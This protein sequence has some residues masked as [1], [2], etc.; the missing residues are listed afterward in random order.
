MKRGTRAHTQNQGLQIIS[1]KRSQIKMSFGMV[2]S[3]ILIIIFL[4]FAF[5]GIKKFLDM[6]I[7]IQTAQFVND[8]QADIDKIWKGSQGSQEVTYTLPKK[9]NEVCF[10]D[11]DYNNLYFVSSD[12]MEDRQIKNI[13]II[14]I[15]EDKDPF[16]IVNKGGKV[17]MIIKKDY[18]ENLV[19][20]IT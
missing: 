20:I 4:A 14:K 8:L 2:F 5:Y 10:T 18:G 7:T 16:C 6:Q 9:I 17:E 3:I 1:Y 11:N 13:D 15:T 19:T 12:Y